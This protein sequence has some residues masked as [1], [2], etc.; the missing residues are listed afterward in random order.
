MGS[1]GAVNG[2]ATRQLT[3]SICDGWVR[4][5]SIQLTCSIH[6]RLVFSSNNRRRPRH[7]LQYCSRHHKQGLRATWGIY[8]LEVLSMARKKET[9]CL[10]IYTVD[11][12]V[13]SL[14]SR[15]SH[16]HPSCRHDCCSHRHSVHHA[17]VSGRPCSL[18]PT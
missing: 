3:Y 11:K 16:R 6:D 8:T 15:N 4:G 9:F 14:L 10:R 13:Y 2:G 18:F 12:I 17:H 7:S 1:N 5:S